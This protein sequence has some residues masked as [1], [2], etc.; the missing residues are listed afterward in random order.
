MYINSKFNILDPHQT[1]VDVIANV[2]KDNQWKL[3]EEIDFENKGSDGQSVPK[4]LGII[5]KSML[6]WELAI[7]DHMDLTEPERRNITEGRNKDRP[8]LQRY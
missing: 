2:P 5:A 8:D 3:N 7:A 6:D 1:I 4:H